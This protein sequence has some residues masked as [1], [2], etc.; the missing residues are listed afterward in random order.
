MIPHLI[1]SAA[2][3]PSFSS[4]HLKSNSHPRVF[5]LSFGCIPQ[6]PV[7]L[8]S[9][10]C[11]WE[12]PRNP[13]V[14]TPHS[15]MP[16]LCLEQATV[17]SFPPPSHPSE[18]PS[19]LCHPCTCVG[20][21]Q[22]LLAFTCLERFFFPCELPCIIFTVSMHFFSQ[23][24]EHTLY[25]F[26]FPRYLPP[27]PVFIASQNYARIQNTNECTG[28]IQQTRHVGTITKVSPRS[29]SFQCLFVDY[30]K[31]PSSANQCK[32][33]HEASLWETA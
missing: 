31:Y 16:S 15:L 19:C 4:V 1:T 8:R 30:M 20:A 21:R 32:Q 18:I 5:L 3:K 14:L 6:P 22:P 17:L 29:L 24:D 11:A 10:A 9:P 2:H 27:I 7:M 28:K 13:P 23:P 33:S 12:S 25:C 26:H